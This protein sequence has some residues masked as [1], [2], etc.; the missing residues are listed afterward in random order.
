MYAEMFKDQCKFVGICWLNVAD[1]LLLSTEGAGFSQGLPC[2][3]TMFPNTGFP[4]LHTGH[5][6]QLE[7]VVDNDFSFHLNQNSQ[8]EAKFENSKFIGPLFCPHLVSS[9]CAVCCSC[10]LLVSVSSLLP[11]S[12]NMIHHEL[13]KLVL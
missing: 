7:H 12:L 13:F 4:V 10:V 6:T 3:S 9:Q 2:C 11:A 1:E 5:L 8:I